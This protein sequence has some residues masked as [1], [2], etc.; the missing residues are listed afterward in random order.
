MKER[1]R[2]GKPSG[3]VPETKKAA[4]AA[5]FPERPAK[6]AF[7]ADVRSQAKEPF[8]EPPA[9]LPEDAVVGRNAVLELLK[10]GRDVNRLLVAE[11]SPA[12]SLAEI[13]A[14]ARA[15]GV[16]VET[17]T[18]SRLD[19]IAAGYRHQGVLAYA[20]PVPYADLDELLD[21][22]AA[23]DSPPFLLLLDGIEDPQNLGA[24]LRT[25]DAAGVSGVIIPKRRSCPL[26]AAVAKTSAG[27]VEYVPVARAA[28]LVQTIG[29]LKERGYW[30]AGADMTG[31]AE[32]YEAD[33]TGALAL[34]IGGEGK[35]LSR[36]VKEKCDFLV[37]LPMMG[38]INSLNASVAAA[39]L[40][41]EAVRQ[42]RK[43]SDRSGR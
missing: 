4:G 30:V 1:K 35:G 8:A 24:I 39:V 31:R 23:Q 34:V 10:G 32:Y 40:M 29:R 43:A 11:G 14:R 41:Y 19:A 36:L 6:Q 16:I 33:L 27:A 2:G 12:G 21:T 20:A 18:R 7:P 37:R 9:V 3:R 42:R 17:V 25:A 5:P 13:L 26:S 15:Q 28:N 22:A 38:R